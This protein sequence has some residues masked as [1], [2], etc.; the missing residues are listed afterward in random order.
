MAPSSFATARCRYRLMS[1]C[2]TETEARSA[3]KSAL[4]WSTPGLMTGLP[5]ARTRAM[6]G[7]AYRT[8]QSLIRRST[9]ARS[10]L[11]PG[12]SPSRL[13]SAAWALRC[14]VSPLV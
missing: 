4:P 8:C 6:V 5:L 7:V 9:V 2:S 12:T 13:R 11:A 3:S 14:W 1:P 10:R